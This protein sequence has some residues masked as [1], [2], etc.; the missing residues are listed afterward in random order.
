MLIPK[1]EWPMSKEE[2]IRLA[3]EQGFTAGVIDTAQ[4]P[5]DAKF[6]PFCEE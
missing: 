1:E 2:L 5:V 6:R 3:E 4:I